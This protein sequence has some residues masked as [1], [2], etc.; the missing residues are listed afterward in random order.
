[1][2]PFPP[3][4]KWL[5]KTPEWIRAD[6]ALRHKLNIIRVLHVVGTC[7]GLLFFAFIF[8]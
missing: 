4:Y 5:F 8:I 3:P 1:M 7:V 6:A 2:R